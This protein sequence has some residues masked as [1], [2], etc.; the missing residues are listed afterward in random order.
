MHLN[1]SK[2]SRYLLLLP[3]ALACHCV[4]AIAQE[5]TTGTVVGVVKEENGSVVPGASITITHRATGAQRTVTTKEA[6]EFSIPGLLPAIYDIKVEKT[7]FRT[8]LIEALELKINQVARLE[9]RLQVGAIT[10]S[11]TVA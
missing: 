4:F 6:G 11:I 2:M 3:L 5:L 7:G 10:E 1:T 9:L 8:Y